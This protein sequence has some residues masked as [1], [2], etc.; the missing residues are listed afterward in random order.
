[1]P[2]S[3]TNPVPSGTRLDGSGTTA[4]ACQAKSVPYWPV[5]GRPQVVDDFLNCHARTPDNQAFFGFQ[6]IRPDRDRRFGPS[7]RRLTR[8]FMAEVDHHLGKTLAWES[9]DPPFAFLP[10]RLRQTLECLLAGDGEKQ[11]ARRLGIS[12]H[13]VHDYVKELYRR[14]GVSTRAELLAR[15]L[16]PDP[17]AQEDDAEGDRIIR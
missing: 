16:R 6:F 3:P 14:L 15:C 17:P 1:M 8:L 4:V 11:V 5:A 12:R 10:P 7:E 9:P 13:T 2:I